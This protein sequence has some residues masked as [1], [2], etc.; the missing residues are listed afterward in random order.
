MAKKK[1]SS[2]PYG[3]KSSHAH[4][5][6]MKTVAEIAASNERQAKTISGKATPTSKKAAVRK[7]AAQSAVRKIEQNRGDYR[8][9]RRKSILSRKRKRSASRSK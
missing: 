9:A 3:M 4:Q 8:A 5:R 7:K 6:L 1:R 2:S